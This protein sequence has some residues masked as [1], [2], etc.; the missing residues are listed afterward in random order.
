MD[1]QRVNGADRRG[2]FPETTDAL[3]AAAPTI[4]FGRPYTPDFVGWMDDFSTTGGYDAHRRL[5]ARLD[6]PLRDPLRRRAEDEAV[7]PLPGRERAARRRR[8]QRLHGR[9]RPRRSTATRTRGRWARDPARGRR[10]R[11]RARSWARRR[12]RSARSTTTT[13]AARPTS[14]SSTTPSG[15]PRAATSRSPACGPAR[16]P[17]FKVDEGRAAA[18]SRR[19]KAEVTEPGLADLRKD[20]R[21]EIRPQ[22]L[23]GEYFVDC[24]PGTSD[25][26]H[27]RRR[28]PARGADQLHDRD[29]PGERHHAAPLS[30]APPPDRGRARRG[31]RGP[32]GR[33]LRRC[34]AAR[35]RRCARRARRSRSSASQTKTIKKFIGDAHTVIGALENRKQ[36]VV[37]F[38]REAGR[39]AEISAS[40]RQRARRDLPPPARPSWPSSSPT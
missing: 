23:I 8:Q 35:I 22:S 9:R 4:A 12:W 39:T 5:L 29:R 33:P 18:R 15:S 7:Q 2:A 27:P 25:E 19:V 21:C 6:Q 17:T 10:P 31:P 28:P 37:R 38:V 13:A 14:C 3:K 16:P 24:Q 26:R 11:G 32:P 34:S 40:R 30:R 36:D 20:A 1:D